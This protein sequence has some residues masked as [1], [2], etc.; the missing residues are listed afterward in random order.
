MGAGRPRKWGCH[1]ESCLRIGGRG[2]SPGGRRGGGRGP[3]VAKGSRLLPARG[4]FGC[5]AGAGRRRPP[6]HSL[7]KS[8]GPARGPTVLRGPGGRAGTLDEW[9]RGRGTSCLGPHPGPLPEGFETAGPRASS[10]SQLRSQ[11]PPPYSPARWGSAL[12]AA[13]SSSAGSK[14]P[15]PPSLQV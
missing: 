7:T 11:R 1:W 4:A 14:P 13:L 3:R 12:P 9:R 10:P 8:D 2:D 6:R 5:A 15:R